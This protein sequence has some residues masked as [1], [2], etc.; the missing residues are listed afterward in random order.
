MQRAFLGKKHIMETQG[1]LHVLF[2]LG[3]FFNITKKHRLS[4]NMMDFFVAF[5]TH[6][7]FFVFLANRF[8]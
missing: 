4:N 2:L 1:L 6:Y 5:L 3:D 8:F 7:C